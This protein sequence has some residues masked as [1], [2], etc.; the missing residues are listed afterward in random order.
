MIGQGGHADTD[1]DMAK[2]PEPAR[3]GSVCSGSVFV[4]YKNIV[5][6]GFNQVLYAT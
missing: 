6:S 2:F 5:C 3:D 1:A 4:A